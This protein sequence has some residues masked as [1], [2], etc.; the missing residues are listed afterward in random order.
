MPFNL[1]KFINLF[2]LF[3]DILKPTRS[4]YL[5]CKV[6]GKF[7]SVIFIS[8]RKLYNHGVGIFYVAKLF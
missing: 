3:V 4:K 7:Y 1:L 2:Y 6:Q 8:S 5:I